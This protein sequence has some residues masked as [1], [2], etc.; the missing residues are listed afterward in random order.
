M[1]AATMLAGIGEPMAGAP[2]MSTVQE[3]RS[4]SAAVRVSLVEQDE[5]LRAGCELYL[6]ADSR[7]QVCSISDGADAQETTAVMAHAVPHVVILGVGVLTE[8][9]ASLVDSLRLACP[10][11]GVVIMC[12]QVEPGTLVRLRELSGWDSGFA[13]LVRGAEHAWGRLAQVIEAVAAG[14]VILDP[15]MMSGLLAESGHQLTHLS[16]REFETLELMAL[17]HTNGDIA[18]AMYLEVKTVERHINSLYGKLGESVH[19][20]HSRVKAVNVY[21]RA[22]GRLTA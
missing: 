7:F 6:A 22:M 4:T 19:E 1:R 21:L 8:E 20:G 16:P 18:S 17:G 2:V 9:R 12:A 3:T 14:R 10:G 15:F 11:V 13:L 5:I